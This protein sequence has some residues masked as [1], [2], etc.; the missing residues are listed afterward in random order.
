VG[1]LTRISPQYLRDRDALGIQAATSISRDIGGVVRTL[2]SEDALPAPGDPQG[3]M[4]GQGAAPVQTFA[5]ARKV[6][7]R[8]LWVWYQVSG[9]E[10]RIVG[11]TRLLTEP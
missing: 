2:A 8:N 1:R 5:Y 4:P 9:D 3:I 6:A 10:V 11:L 7:G